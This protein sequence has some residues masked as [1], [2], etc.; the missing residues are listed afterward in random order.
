E[1][2]GQSEPAR[3]AVLALV[4][5]LGLLADC[6][7]QLEANRDAAVRL[8][9]T[10]EAAADS[11]H[12]L[13]DRGGSA[14][15]LDLA[16][17]PAV[18]LLA[19]TL[20]N[21]EWFLRENLT[22]THVASRTKRWMAA[23]KTAARVQDVCDGLEKIRVDVQA[24]SLQAVLAVSIAG[25]GAAAELSVG[26]TARLTEMRRDM[27]ADIRK[28]L[29]VIASCSARASETVR[30]DG[31]R[32][33]CFADFG[34][35][36]LDLVDD[37]LLEAR[38]RVRLIE[39]EITYGNFNSGSNDEAAATAAAVRT[40][41][42]AILRDLTKQAERFAASLKRKSILQDWMLP[43]NAVCFSQDDD[44]FVNEGG[45][46]RVFIG[47]MDGKYVAVK[48][49]K[50]VGVSSGEIERSIVQEIGA[51]RSVSDHDC[52]VTLL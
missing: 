25:A 37:L 32:A 31:A 19:D 16:A 18:R 49:F 34:D 15:A 26:L 12:R 45:F 17:A 24:A 52:I 28:E 11:L 47:K 35:R 14:A 43:A 7:L 44:S 50:A 22:P 46:S 10:C 9:V 42:S 39:E 38:H 33:A 36:K 48:V 30:R 29:A 27:S 8:G 5:V 40:D 20:T 21:A 1:E 3:T 23:F 6:V 2:E 4:G 41:A 51:W 13:L